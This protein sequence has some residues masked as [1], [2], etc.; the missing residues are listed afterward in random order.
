MVLGSSLRTFQKTRAQVSRGRYSVI[1]TTSSV[2]GV[3][4]GKE[5]HTDNK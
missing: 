5:L 1:E 3:F 4:G 2:S